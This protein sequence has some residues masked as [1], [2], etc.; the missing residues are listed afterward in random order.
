[1]EEIRLRCINCGREYQEEDKRIFCDCGGNLDLNYFI[2]F[3]IENIDRKIVTYFLFLTGS[4]KD[5]GSTVLIS[6]MRE[7]GIKS[8]NILPLSRDEVH[9]VAKDYSKNFYY[10]SHFLNHILFKVLK[11]YFLK[12]L[13]S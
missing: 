3:K 13:R 8:L 4:F 5:R 1:M 2:D 11:L 10:A 9:F 6:K 12:F 7:L